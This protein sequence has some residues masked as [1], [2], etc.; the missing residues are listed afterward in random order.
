MVGV[1]GCFAARNLGR[2]M[3]GALRDA[4]VFL[5]HFERPKQGVVVGGLAA[6]GHVVALVWLRMHSRPVAQMDV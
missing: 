4:R 3:L 5:E 6:C 2:P 1:N